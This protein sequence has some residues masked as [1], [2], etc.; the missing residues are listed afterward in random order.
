M[1]TIN[2]IAKIANVSTSTVSHVVNKTRYVSPELVERVEHAIR[3]LD[4]LPNFVVKKTQLTKQT[5]VTKYILFLIS[6]VKSK[7]QTQ[8]ERAAEAELQ[9]TSYSLLSVN[10]GSDYRR[11]NILSS[12][13]LDTP[14]IAGA[15]VFPDEEDRIIKN[16]LADRK[17][18]LVIVGRPVKDYI[19]DTIYMDTFE[20]AY[21][22]TKHLIKN[23]HEHI[24]FMSSAQDRSPRR[25]DGY[26][27]ALKDYGIEF[28]PALSFT[29]LNTSTEIYAKLNDLLASPLMPTAVL[30]ANYSIMIPL[31]NYIESHNILCPNDLSIVSFND[32]DWAPLHTPPITTVDQN[33]KELAELA[34]KTLLMRIEKEEYANLPA[35]KDAYKTTKLSAKLNV[36]ASTCGIGRGPF[37][38]KAASPET[39]ILSESETNII[40][41]RNLTAVISFHYQGK[42]WMELIQK[43]IKEIFDNLNISIIAITDAHFDYKLQCKQLDS[44]LTLDPD[45]IIAFPTDNSKTK[46]AFTRIAASRAKLV[47]ISNVPDGL[48][49]ADYVTCVSVNERSHGRN[50]GEGLGN[51]MQKHNMKNLGLIKHGT[52]FYTTNQRDNAAEQVLSEEYPELHICCTTTFLHENEVYQKTCELIKNFPEITG[53]YVPWEGP[54]T[55]AMAALTFLNRTDVVIAT[56]DLDYSAAM[57]MAKGGMI[58]M[59]SAQCPFEQG[60]AMALASANGILGKDTPS[61][62]GIEPI[63]VTPENL[64]KSWSRVFKTEPDSNLRQAFRQNPNYISAKEVD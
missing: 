10:Y 49:P 11:L 9:N 18:P 61:F 32:F 6:D 43:G 40:K 22:A 55:E 27:K 58:K 59:I 46:E 5:T 1:A 33:P 45:I 17:L 15:M 31:L 51:F 3:D 60:Q 56:G 34:I 19:A 38:E 29:N 52:N 64:L 57:N 37:G 41:N 54:A 23:G 30:T 24:I 63:I 25:L 47:L 16:V 28:E 35:L 21:K 7:F 39:L 50:I 8:V 48:T 14:G 36:R 44:L 62:I 53:L 26:K 4:Y 42:S 12:Y 13:L 20:G 2:D